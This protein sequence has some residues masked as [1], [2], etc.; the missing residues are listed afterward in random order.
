MDYRALPNAWSNEIPLVR[1]LLSTWRMQIQAY[2]EEQQLVPL[3]DS[4]NL[5]VSYMRNRIRHEL[6]PLLEGYN[7]SIRETL[8][9]MGVTIREDHALLQ[10]LVDRAWET[11]L[12]YHGEEKLALHTGLFLELPLSVQRMLLRKAIALLRP[13]LRDVDFES[14]ERGLALL[15]GAKPSTQTDLVAGLRLLKEGAQFWIKTW[16][17]QLPTEEFPALTPVEAREL[18]IP[19][20]IFLPHGWQLDVEEVQLSDLSG[21]LWADTFDPF[22]AWID[23]QN[24]DKPLMVRVRKPGDHIEPLGLNGHSVKISDLMVNLK[25][26]SRVRATWPLV[27]SGD[28]VIWVP[29]YRISQ[30]VRI[31]PDTLRVVH[32]KLFRLGTT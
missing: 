10:Q 28:E 11:V 1:P 31:T 13:G 24:L 17:A 32:L 27:S 18:H 6:I 21:L 3:F 26:P 30:R 22:E 14:I 19:S 2:L 16:Q 20:T 5:D 4:S 23:I 9:R 12:V 15:A 25:L 29:G 7:P 8:Q